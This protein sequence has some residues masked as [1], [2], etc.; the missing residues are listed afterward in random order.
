[1]EHSE[2]IINLAKALV[3]FQG[4]V[5]DPA[6]DKDNGFVKLSV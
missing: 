4:K 5:K 3:A 1:M 6:K 2:S